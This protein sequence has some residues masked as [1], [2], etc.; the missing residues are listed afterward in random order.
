[1]GPYE[2]EGM[3]ADESAPSE[4]QS[5]PAEDNTSDEKEGSEGVT[6]LVPKSICPGMDLE[7]G[8]K[9][10]FEVV[11]TYEDEVEIKYLKGDQGKSDMAKSEEDLNAMAEVP[12]A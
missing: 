11:K 1:M 7:P 9:L 5:E 10:E 6:A 3:P 8:Q 2:N 12:P 4:A